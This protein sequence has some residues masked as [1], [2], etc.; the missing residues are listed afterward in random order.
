ML[1]CAEIDASC[2]SI[3]NQIVQTGG[4][5]SFDRVL[6][7]LLSSHGMACEELGVFGGAL[8]VPCL[9]QLHFLQRKIDCFVASFMGTRSVATLQDLEEE[10]VAMLRT[11]CARPLVAVHDVDNTN[12]EEIELSD[13]DNAKPESTRFEQY[14]IGPF[15]CNPIVAQHFW[16]GGHQRPE[17]SWFPLLRAPQVYAYLLQYMRE[18]RDVLQAT[19]G[20]QVEAFRSSLV[21]HYAE[22]YG[23]TDVRQ[24]G[25]VIRE[26]D[27][28]VGLAEEALMIR[29]VLKQEELLLQQVQK[30]FLEQRA[31]QMERMGCGADG[32]RNRRRKQR[33][34]HKD[35]KQPQ[36]E[37]E[38]L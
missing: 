15:A 38:G 28:G 19:A 34:K 8:A 36:E 1:Q 3:A 9:A 12:P 14:G 21:M 27:G 35:Q 4:Y 32:S 16:T 23:V 25:V 22:E 11:F 33:R 2:R 7:A 37:E 26:V 29:H 31:R 20:V 30:E 6:T 17:A 10:T 13:E 5:V 24:L 18:H